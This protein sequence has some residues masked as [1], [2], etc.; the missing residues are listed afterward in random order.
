MPGSRQW[1]LM[2]AVLIQPALAV[3]TDKPSNLGD[4]KE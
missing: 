4:L 2:E 1:Y 3:V